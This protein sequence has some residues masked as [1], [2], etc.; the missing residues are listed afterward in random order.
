[1]LLGMDESTSYVGSAM[2]NWLWHVSLPLARLTLDKEGAVIE[3][4]ARVLRWLFPRKEM[5]WR[6]VTKVVRTRN[7]VRFY[8]V[9]EGGSTNF[10]FGGE[11]DSILDQIE[12]HGIHVERTP[13]RSGS[14]G[15][16]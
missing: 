12:M 6:H 5:S 2:V 11:P 15:G 16:D 7:G 9:G 1:M 4:S 14:W 8:I 10:Q 3:P 13:H